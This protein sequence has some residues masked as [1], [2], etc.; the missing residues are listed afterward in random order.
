MVTDFEDRLRQIRAERD[1]ET[2]AK[3]EEVAAANQQRLS[4]IEQRFD[5]R[6]KIET[7]IVALAERFIGEVQAF[8]QTKSFFEG[9]YKIEVAHEDLIVDEA[10]MPQ[11]LFSRIAFLLD[12]TSTDG[13]IHVAVKKTVRNRDQDG[14]NTSVDT[15][16]ASMEDF[17]RFT[18]EQF[19]GFADTYFTGPSG[20]SRSAR[21]PVAPAI[22]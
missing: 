8:A 22:R 5:R 21:G 20:S 10:G 6:E 17:T 18:E 16:S 1:R 12:T 14:V 9:K 15:S 7:A 4:T 19:F 2:R 3:Q 11:K 13:T